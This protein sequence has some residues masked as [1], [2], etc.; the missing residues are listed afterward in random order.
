MY[1]SRS[2]SH[3]HSSYHKRGTFFPFLIVRLILSLILFSIFGFGIY[4]AI[5]YF[6][7]VDPI[8]IDPQKF[9]VE[10]MSSDSSAN[11]ISKLFNIDPKALLKGKI[12]TN[13]TPASSDQSSSVDS[14]DQPSG[15]KILTFAV[16]ADSHNKNE[17][18]KKALSQAKNGGAKF[19]IGDGDYTDVGTT[20]DFQAA[21]AVFDKSG[22]PYYLTAGDHDLWNSRDKGFEADHFFKEVFGAP[23]QSFGDSNIRFIIVFNSDNYFGVDDFQMNWL[24]QELQ[25]VK[26]E[27]PLQTFVFLHEP[28]YH[29]SSDHVM[30]KTNPK[31]DD[32]AQTLIQKFK[33]A[34]V[35]EVISGDVH[36][37]S[38]Y[39]E[40]QSGLKMTVDGALTDDRNVQTPR[41]LMVD[42]YDNGSYNIQDTEVK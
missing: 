18:L 14:Q 11:A 13:S 9:L 2:S 36:Y 26:M 42:V 17:I 39:S 38:R 3:G 30:G 16:V 1:H 29:P 33:D 8:N 41:F 6:S 24:D 35:G 5:V 32:Q 31:L 27:K 25:R 7:G 10:V 40:P 28:L 23:Y 22:M 34:G 12:S 19:V 37:Y 20:E 15:T 21:K 4:R